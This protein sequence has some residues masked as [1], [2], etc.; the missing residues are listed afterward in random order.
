MKR[1]NLELQPIG[2]IHSPYQDRAEAPYQGRR[3]EGISRIELF[4]EFE[5]GLRDIEGFSH[6]IVIY[7]FHKSQ[8]YHLLV[9]TPW[10]DIPHGLFATRSPHRPCPLGLTVAELVVREKNIL[11]IKGLDAI[12]GTPLLD[13]KPYIPA[14]D[15]RSV[16]K[17]G[18][19]EGKLG[20]ER[21]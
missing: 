19:L 1:H 7:W 13:I 20:K 9:K 2:I 12:D 16:V 14:I 5:E 11:E 15:E 3:S 18:W 17:L 6:I 4:K 21:I 8:G 10:D